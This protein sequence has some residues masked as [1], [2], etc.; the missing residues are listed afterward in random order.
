VSV[1]SGQDAGRQDVSLRPR[2]IRRSTATEPSVVEPA[3]GDR[4]GQS[5]GLAVMGG[6]PGQDRGRFRTRSEDR[7]AL[8]HPPA[9]R[10]L[11]GQAADQGANCRIVDHRLAPFEE[12]GSVTA[13]V[14]M[15]RTSL[16]DVGLPRGVP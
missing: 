7:G 10:V 9:R 14:P 1:D 4:R 5:L 8:D 15:S 2:G 12:P 16:S 6:D 13:V 11:A 3:S